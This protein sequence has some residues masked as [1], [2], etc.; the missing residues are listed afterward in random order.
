MILGANEMA[1]AIFFGRG[2]KLIIFTYM[3]TIL[4]R[5]QQS[6]H[7]IARYTMSRKADVHLS[8]PPQV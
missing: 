6:K 2:I 3:L 1:Y 4:L 7:N 5:L 8:F